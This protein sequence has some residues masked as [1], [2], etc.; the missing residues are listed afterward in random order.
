LFA[1]SHDMLCIAGFD[2][3]FKQVNPAWERVFGWSGA[4]LTSRPYIEFVHPDDRGATATEAVNNQV[5]VRT[6]QF[7]NRFRSRDGSHRWLSWT[8]VPS[9]GERLI[10][11]A[12]RDITSQKYLAD[13]TQARLAVS[14]IAAEAQDWA[15][16]GPAIAEALC[17]AL[18]WDLAA[19]WTVVPD[20]DSLELTSMWSGPG[21]DLD[22]ATLVSPRRTRGQSL[23]GMAWERGEPVVMRD[24]LS[25]DRFTESATAAAHGLHGGLALPIR[26]QG[27]LECVLSF[28]SKDIVRFEDELLSTLTELSVQIGSLMDRLALQERIR[29]MAYHDPLTGLP[30]RSLFRERASHALALSRRLK[31]PIGIGMVDVDGFK[32]INDTLG[33]VIGDEVLRQVGQRLE[34]ALRESDTVAR[35]GG[36]EFG[37]VLESLKDESIAAVVMRLRAAFDQSLA[38]S[39]GPLKVRSSIGFAVSSA[40]EDDDIDRLLRTADHEMYRDKPGG[41]SKSGTRAS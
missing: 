24:V 29:T 22:A 2:G 34:A 32:A 35:L 26:S 12:A 6:L 40:G 37:V 21:I 33:H 38:L 28:L 30:N 18:D 13:L 19:V 41:R 15:T 23:A 5:G 25:D 3:Y 31:S 36:D 16:A 4:Q 14:R 8:A 11:A 9:E 20:A 17:R 27:T 10:Y 39:T 1:A 7:E